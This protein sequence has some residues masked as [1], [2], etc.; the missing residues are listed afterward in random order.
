MVTLHKPEVIVTKGEAMPVMNKHSLTFK[1]PF[2]GFSAGDKVDCFIQKFHDGRFAVWDSS[3]LHHN[4][5]GVITSE[6]E[7]HDTFDES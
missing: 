4:R 5:Y 7:L 3:W 1:K 2:I 6:K